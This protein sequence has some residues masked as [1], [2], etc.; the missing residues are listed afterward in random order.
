MKTIL[1]FML[2]FVLFASFPAAAVTY[3]ELDGLLKSE[4]AVLIDADTGQVLFEKNMREKMRPASITKVMTALLALEYGNPGDIIVLSHEAVHSLD[5]RGAA[6]IEL[7]EDEEITLLDALYALSIRSANEA[8]NG[9][10]EHIGGSLEAFNAL[11]NERALEAGAL[12]TNF[13]NAHGMPCDEHLTTA[14]DMALIMLAAVRTPGFCE[15]FSALEYTIPPT[16]IYEEPRVLTGSNPMLP[17]RRLEYKGIIAE[18][19]GYTNASQHTLVTAAER[20]GRRLICVV[21]KSPERDDKY[22][23]TALLLDFG[24]ERFEKVTYTAE[25]LGGL[26]DTD[27][28]LAPEESFS[29]LLPKGAAKEDVIPDADGNRLVFSLSPSLS[30]YAVLGVLELKPVPEEP[31]EAAAV[32]S[33]EISG[34]AREQTALERILI[35]IAII[36]AGI[37]GLCALLFIVLLIIRAVNIWKYRRRQRRING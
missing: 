16:N 8:T 3:P 15:L 17:S 24:F 26:I 14:Y 35:W 32:V 20:D 19:T 5:G 6:N 33:A 18:K 37:L 25:E 4:A 28:F 11:M 34:E 29:R 9:V 7:A 36:F 30:A 27:K 21:L 10:A 22:E 2:V 1:T 13:T 12:S 31:E 23:D